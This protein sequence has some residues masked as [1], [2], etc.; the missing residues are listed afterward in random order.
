MKYLP[1]ACSGEMIGGMCMSEP[2]AGS[3]VFAMKSVAKQSG[4]SGYQLTGNKMWITNGCV[5]E[6]DPGDVFL[7]YARTGE[8]ANPKEDFTQFVVESKFKGFSLGSKIM[9]KCGMRAS[10]TA[11]L[12][13]D[14][15]E[16]PPENVVGQVGKAHL[17]MMRNLELE[18]L[19][20]AAMSLGIARRCIDVMNQY[21]T[22]RPIFGKSLRQYGQ[23]QAFIADSYAEYM[24]ARSYTYETANRTKLNE[25]GMRL[26]SDGVKLFAGVTGKRVADRAIQVLG[27]NGYIGDY[28]VE[29]LWRDSK[30]LE[31]GGGTN[32]ILQVNMTR[33]LKK[34]DYLE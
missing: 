29:R 20:L 30:L 31:I 23:I 24:A 17:C 21:A 10:G 33:D 26:D 28:H 11:E 7:V 22:D 12:V 9:D 32:E 14:S 2:S 5:N 15:C 1:K 27:G 16:V 18:R 34:I 25:A 4:S 13:F 19:T 8:N 3:D 6:T